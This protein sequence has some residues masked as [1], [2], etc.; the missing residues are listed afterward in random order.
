MFKKATN[1]RILTYFEIPNGPEI[2]ALSPIFHIS[3]KVAP[4]TILSKID[5][6]PEETFQQ[7][8]R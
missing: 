2:W 6:N 3:L 7:D 5:V 1:T 8:I 4:I